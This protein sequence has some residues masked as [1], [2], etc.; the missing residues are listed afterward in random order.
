MYQQKPM[1][2]VVTI[3]YKFFKTIFVFR[4]SFRNFNNTCSN[5]F[6]TWTTKPRNLTNSSALKNAPKRNITYT[7]SAVTKIGIGLSTAA[8]VQLCL[9]N[10][11]FCE[12]PKQTNRIVGYQG[13]HDR[14]LKFDWNRFWIYLKPHIWY[15]IAAAIVSN[16]IFRH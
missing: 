6:R 14:N 8:G 5:N 10:Q 3:S 16:H 2:E 13:S 1:V 15:F 7:F 4:H 9:K 11:V 12:A